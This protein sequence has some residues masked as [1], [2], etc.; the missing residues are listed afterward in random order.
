[1]ITRLRESS[2]PGSIGSMAKRRRLHLG[3]ADDF[4]ARVARR[5]FEASIKLADSGQ[6]REALGRMLLAA[7]D[8]GAAKT[9]ERIKHNVEDAE[10]RATV[11]FH[12]ACIRED[13][14]RAR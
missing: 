12:N 4:H 13:K 5:Q 9:R 6:C 8:G 11:A 7:R 2:K 14:W 1:M 10:S 3:S